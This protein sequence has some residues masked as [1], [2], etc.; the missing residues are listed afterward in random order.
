MRIYTRKGDAGKTFLFR[1]PTKLA[2]SDEVFNLL[3]DLDFLNCVLSLVRLE[4]EKFDVLTKAQIPDLVLSI[5]ELIFLI[6]SEINLGKNS[7]NS[8]LILS[9]DINLLENLIDKFWAEAGELRSFVIPGGSALSGLIHI[10]RALTR[11]VERRAVK[12][13]PRLQLRSELIAFL[14]RLSDLMFALARCVDKRLG[15]EELQWRATETLARF[16]A[17]CDRIVGEEFS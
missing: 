12:L 11:Q 16:R 1:S 15:A 13:K 9:S 10:A 14:N 6:G 8:D 3:G 7:N 2:K 4:A 5:Q 17:V